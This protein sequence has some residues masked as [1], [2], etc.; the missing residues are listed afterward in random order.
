MKDAEDDDW[1]DLDFPTV[2]TFLP[3]QIKTSMAEFIRLADDLQKHPLSDGAAHISP[4]GYVYGGLVNDRFAFLYDPEE[5][6]EARR[7]NVHYKDHKESPLE[8]EGA[9]LEEAWENILR[10]SL[11]NLEKAIVEVK[12]WLVSVGEKGASDA[13]QL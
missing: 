11:G 6:D 4:A 1:G 7:Y 8:A 10:A 3:A 5:P 9:T 12:K 13:E 2:G